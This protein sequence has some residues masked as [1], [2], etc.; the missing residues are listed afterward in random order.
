MS[1]FPRRLSISAELNTGSKRYLSLLSDCWAETGV[2]ASGVY[3]AHRHIGFTD[4]MYSPLGFELARGPGVKLAGRLLAVSPRT[5]FGP[6]SLGNFWFI[7]FFQS[8]LDATVSI[9]DKEEMPAV[10][11]VQ[12]DGPVE[13][14][15]DGVIELPYWNAEKAA[16]GTLRFD[17]RQNELVVEASGSRGLVVCA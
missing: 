11:T 10:G 13:A 2:G 15:E 17:V 4:I 16:H 8:A 14:I 3:V 5:W 6:I 9:P 7:K 1:P 12:W